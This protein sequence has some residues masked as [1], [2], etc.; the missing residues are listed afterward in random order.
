[1]FFGKFWEMGRVCLQWI[2]KVSSLDFLRLDY[3]MSILSL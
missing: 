1:M 3:V 2:L